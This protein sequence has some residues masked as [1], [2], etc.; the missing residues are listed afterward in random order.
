MRELE[1]ALKAAADPTRTRILKLLGQGGLCGC[2][3]Q[4][5]LGLAPSTVSKHLSLLKH[6]GLLQDRRDGR[7][8]EYSLAS[9][10]ANPHAGAVLAMLKGLLEDDPVVLADSR[11]LAEVQAVSRAD[12]CSALSGKARSDKRPRSGDS[13]HARREDR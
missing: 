5:V 8:I 1:L 11:R 13:P 12:L 2:Q 9:P 6:A 10:P 4:E 7:W 3:I